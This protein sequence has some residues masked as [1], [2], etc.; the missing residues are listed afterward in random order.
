[1][2]PN[3]RPILDLC[4]DKLSTS[5][6]KLFTQDHHTPSMEKKMLEEE[7]GPLSFGASVVKRIPAHWTD[8]NSGEHWRFI[9]RLMHYFAASELEVLITAND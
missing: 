2:V 4:Q 9:A 1:M 7:Q 8:V 5:S 3:S 6:P